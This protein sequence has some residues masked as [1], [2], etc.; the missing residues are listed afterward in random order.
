MSSTILQ[1]MNP[2]GRV[3]V[4]GSMSTYNEIPENPSIGNY[5]LR[6]QAFIF[7]EKSCSTVNS[8]FGG[9]STAQSKRIYSEPVARSMAGRH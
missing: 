6:L 5:L 9:N 4:C 1:Q 3:A 8:K 2:F 7:T